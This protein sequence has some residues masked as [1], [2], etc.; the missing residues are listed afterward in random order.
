MSML[1]RNLLGNASP[2]QVSEQTGIP[3]DR[4]ERLFAGSEVPNLLE[5]GEIADA[6]S[7]NPMYLARTRPSIA[8]HRDSGVDDANLND[9]LERFDYHVAAYRQELSQEP[10]A[11]AFPAKRSWGARTHGEKWAQ[12][13]VVEWHGHESPDPLIQA[14]EDRLRIP[15]LIWPVPSAPFGAT[16]RLHN[17]LAIWVNSHN[18]PAS[19]QRFTLAHELGHIMLR[20]VEQSRIEQARSPDEASSVGSKAQQ[21]LEEHANAFAGGVL[22]DYGRVSQFWDGNASPISVARIAAGLGISYDAASVAMSIHLKRQVQGIRDT[23]RQTS[24]AEAFEHANA[25]PLFD[26][27]EQLRGRRRV[28]AVIEHS[29]LLRQ[30]LEQAA[31]N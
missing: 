3:V 9:L 12:R 19:Q 14:I 15:I 23:A 20:H 13:N 16:L 25:S 30:S 7:I 22:Y 6:L 29:D 21:T 4:L 1:D 28:P 11:E 10:V 8:A 31:A 24:A 18:V 27:F 5:I 2:S 17:T 26:W